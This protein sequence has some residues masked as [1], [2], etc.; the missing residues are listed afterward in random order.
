VTAINTFAGAVLDRAGPHRADERW[1]AERRA[2]PAARAVLVGAN[3]PWVREEDGSVVPALVPLSAVRGADD[4]LV[5]LGLDEEGPLFAV[6]SDP[7]AIDGARPMPLREAGAALATPDA[8]LVAYAAAILNWHRAHPHCA[9]CGAR[10]RIAEA[11]FLRVCPRC[12]TEHHPRTD[13]VV[14]M[15]VSD[16]YRV[17]LGRG[18]TWAEGRYSALAG[19]VEPGESLEEAVVRELREEAGVE[20]AGPTYSSSQPWPFPS[21]LML[22]FHARYAGGEPAVRDHE[23][24]DVRWFTAEEVAAGIRGEGPLNVPPPIA[25]ARRLLEEWLDER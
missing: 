11:G 1:V 5:L 13:P 18:P 2:D 25:I 14:I 17:L 24:E 3:G 12:G 20:I 6:A 8:G 15:L 21:S 10:T 4:D 9:R 22:G 23:L 16:G 7:P 19:F